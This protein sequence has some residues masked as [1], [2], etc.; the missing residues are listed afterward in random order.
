ME[1]ADL[2]LLFKS[3]YKSRKGFIQNES[4]FKAGVARGNM[5]PVLSFLRILFSLT[6]PSSTVS[7]FG[8]PNHEW[9]EQW[10][11]L[12]EQLDGELVLTKSILCTNELLQCTNPWHI[13]RKT[14]R[15][16]LGNLYNRSVGIKQSSFAA[17]FYLSDLKYTQDVHSSTHQYTQDAKRVVNTEGFW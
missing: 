5:S 13:Q 16:I 1:N 6:I 11:Q 15:D 12:T 14:K 17:A 9:E 7:V 2:T 3:P 4:G 10:L 8:H